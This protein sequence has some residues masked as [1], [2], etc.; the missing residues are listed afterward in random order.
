MSSRG[1]SVIE[2]LL[3]DIAGVCIRA[4]RGAPAQHQQTQ[5]AQPG[6]DLNDA[7]EEAFRS[8]A[9]EMGEPGVHAPINN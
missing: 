8:L 2:C 7:F 5:A 4:L 6:L 9:A 3:L 1:K